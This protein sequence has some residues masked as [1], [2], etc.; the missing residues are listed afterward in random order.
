MNALNRLGE[1][2]GKASP[3]GISAT[4]PKPS[5]TIDPSWAV[6]MDTGGKYSGTVSGMMNM[7][8]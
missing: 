2:L 5:P 1:G 6:P 4:A 8:G 3:T 7:A